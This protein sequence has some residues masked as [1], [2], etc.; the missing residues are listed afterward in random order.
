M[1]IVIFQP[2]LK[3]YRLDFF[4]QLNQTLVA[5]NHELRVVVGTPWKEERERNDT[6]VVDTGYY[7]FEESYWLFKNKIHILKNVLKHIFW[8]DIIITEQANKHLHNY[9]LLLLSYLNIRPFAYW[10]HGMNRQIDPNSFRERFKRYLAIRPDWWFAYTESVC[11]YLTNIGFDKNRI[12]VLNNSINTLRFKQSINSL[13]SQDILTFKD[14][15][16]IGYNTKIGL[17]CGSL[18]QDKDI[19]F[20]LESAVYI[21]QTIPDFL[22]L[23]GGSGFHKEL[24]ES[25]TK[26]YDFIIYLGRLDGHKKN[27]AFLCADVFLIPCMVGLGIIDAFTTGLPLIT[28]KQN[29]HSPEIDYLKPNYNGIITDYSLQAYAEAVISVLNSNTLL[30]FL[31]SNALS[32]SNLYT[33]ENMVKNFVTGLDKFIA[34]KYPLSS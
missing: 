13:T 12:S 23:I 32:S 6:A 18:H 8:A 17:F 22:L 15:H 21:H 11:E 31:K 10:G 33:I 20:L 28:T 25:Y 26:K 19:H 7:F 29:T 5:N 16:K 24:V 4:E 2:M 3:K 34:D 1:K 27:L 30:E 9:F 14:N